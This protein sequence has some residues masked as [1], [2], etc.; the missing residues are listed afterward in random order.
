MQW[1]PPTSNGMVKINSSPMICRIEMAWNCC[2]YLPCHNMPEPYQYVN[3]SVGWLAC[4][5]HLVYVA[6]NWAPD[7]SL[8]FFASAKPWKSPRTIATPKN[9][10]SYSTVAT[11]VTIFILCLFGATQLLPSLVLNHTKPIET[12]SIHFGGLIFDPSGLWND[13]NSGC[14]TNMKENIKHSHHISRQQ[15]SYVSGCICVFTQSFAV[16]MELWVA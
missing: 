5:L 10:Q 11:V 1:R 14:S 16:P 15:I 3:Q 2:S 4:R 8:M 13:G 12:E 7:G 9:Y 6:T